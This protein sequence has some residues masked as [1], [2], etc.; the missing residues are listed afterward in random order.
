MNIKMSFLTIFVSFFLITLLVPGVS[1]A[2]D[3]DFVTAQLQPYNL[4]AGCSNSG[5]VCDAGSV[6]CNISLRQVQSEGGY[7]LIFQNNMSIAE[8]GD[9]N[10]TFNSTAMGTNGLHPG[11]VSCSDGVANSTEYFTLLVTPSGIDNNNLAYLTLFLG[12]GSFLLLGLALHEDN[13][14]MGFMAGIAF[15]LTSLLIFSQGLFGFQNIYSSGAAGI[16]FV[17][18]A[19]V[20]ISSLEESLN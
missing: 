17:F 14:V 16:Y 15:L 8:N 13:Y 18:F 5:L 11:W 4:I 6:Q 20:G 1:A 3:A 19:W 9:A 7:Y 12:I 10:Y 2:P